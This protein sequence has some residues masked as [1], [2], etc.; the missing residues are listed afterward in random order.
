MWTPQCGLDIS[1][2]PH[3]SGV[4]VEGSILAQRDA[5]AELFPSRHAA[6]DHALVPLGLVSALCAEAFMA[7]RRL[8]SAWGRAAGDPS[9]HP[10]DPCQTRINH[11]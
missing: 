1:V 10:Y 4:A 11:S 9:M 6:A 3:V 5:V 2:S 7:M 8:T